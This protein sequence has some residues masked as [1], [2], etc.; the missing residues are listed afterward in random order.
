[1]I[2]LVWHSCGIIGHGGFEYLF[3]GEFPGDPDYRITPRPVASLESAAATKRFRPRS[4]YFPGEL[5]RTIPSRESGSTSWPT[6][7]PARGSIG[8]YGT[9]SACA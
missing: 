7:P 6:S 1:V 9:T 5:C 3:A 4:V 2:M 8:G